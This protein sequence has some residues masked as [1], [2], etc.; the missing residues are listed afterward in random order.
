MQQVFDVVADTSNAGRADVAEVL[1]HLGSVDPGE[2]GERGRADRRFV[3]SRQLQ[4]HP[5]INRQAHHGCTRNP[6]LHHPAE[7]SWSNQ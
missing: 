4:E 3:G 7:G 1:A 6:S 2:F 5:T